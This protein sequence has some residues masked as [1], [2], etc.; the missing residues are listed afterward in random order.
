[1][2]VNDVMEA[3][4]LGIALLV[5]HLLFL[6]WATRKGYRGWTLALFAVPAVGE[7]VYLLYDLGPRWRG[8]M[9]DA[10]E[11][12]LARLHLVNRCPRIIRA[13]EKLRVLEVQPDG[14]LEVQA[15][16]GVVARLHPR[17]VMSAGEER[18]AS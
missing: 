4:R 17:E 8:R 6:V 9:P 12:V 10:G 3:L 15:A 5:A 13:G 16:G 11:I 2:G 18:L 7:A 14:M 1:M